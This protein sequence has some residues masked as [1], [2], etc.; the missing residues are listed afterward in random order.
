MGPAGMLLSNERQ[1]CHEPSSL[2]GCGN[3]M[4]AGS[5]TTAFPTTHDPSLTID[6][7]L[8]EFDVLVID[9][10]GP[11]TLTID[12]NRIFLACAGAN[13]GAF[14]GTA[15]RAHWSWG[16]GCL[17][18]RGER[19]K[20]P[21]IVIYRLAIKT[22]SGHRHI[23]TRSGLRCRGESMSPRKL[24]RKGKLDQDLPFREPKT[25]AIFPKCSD[26]WDFFVDG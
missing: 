14:A 23:P 20:R 15:T 7:F 25:F 8:Q 19:S 24:G 21:I 18:F 3:C 5:G 6:H 16:H 10:H 17:K 2:D 13:S 1:Q 4:L 12:E 9:V 22:S 26:G 11:R